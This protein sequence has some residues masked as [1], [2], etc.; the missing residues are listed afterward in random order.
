MSKLAYSLYLSNTFTLAKTMVIKHSLMAEIINGAVVRAGYAVNQDDPTT[1]KYY[2]NMA[3]KYHQYDLDRLFKLSGNVTPYMQIT[4]AG[5]FGPVPADFTSILITGDDTQF[6]PIEPDLATANEYRFNSKFYNNLVEKY[7]DFQILIAGILNPID[8]QISVNAN[9]GEIL[10]A[11]GFYKSVNPITLEPNFTVREGISFESLVLIEPHENNLLLKLQEWVYA[12]LNAWSNTSYQ[13]VDELFFQ[14]LWGVMFLNIPL[15][16]LNIRLENTKSQTTHT[17]HITEY[18]ESNGLLGK[19]VKNLPIQTVLYIY[20]NLMDLHSKSGHKLTAKKVVDNVL[21]PTQIPLSKYNLT[22]DQTLIPLELLPSTNLKRDVVNFKQS[23]SGGDVRSIQNILNRQIPLAR[24][25]YL[26]LDE[27]AED[28]TIRCNN[29]RYSRMSTK[30]FD[31]EMLDTRD[32]IPFP[33]ADVLYNYWI[34]TSSTGEYTG[35]IYVTNPATGERVQLNPRSSFILALYCFN[36]GYNDITLVDI[37]NINAMMIP[38]RLAGDP[39]LPLGLLPKP[40][41]IDVLN[42]VDNAKIKITDILSVMPIHVPDYTHTASNTFYNECERIHADLMRCYYTYT[43]ADDKDVR[44]MLEFATSE[45][46]WLEVPCAINNTDLNY[47]DWLNR[48]GINLDNLTQKDYLDFALQIV[49]TVTGLA[50]NKTVNLRDVQLSALAVLQRFNSYT[51]HYISKLSIGNSNIDDGKDLRYSDFVEIIN[52]NVFADII[53]T[54]TLE[55][56]IDTI[57]N[58]TIE[59]YGDNQFDELST[60]LVTTDDI[61]NPVQLSLTDV[62][63]HELIDIQTLLTTVFDIEELP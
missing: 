21:T 5:E 7:P 48:N 8:L 45:S 35:T 18:L 30:V 59:N 14:A 63:E 9:D 23:G 3:G 54:E 50:D 53:F 56:S 62:V 24:N 2:M 42:K 58:F 15:T 16:I 17:Y 28:I 49:E 60:H 13:R 31:S 33:I 12:Y 55:F 52:D 38:R 34:Y 51:V 32:L 6:P 20:K 46:Y 44:A 43:K 57:A 25:N 41:P 47:A 26:N 39:K 11:G 1:W 4:V 37:P 27:K 22:H 29:A 61:I 36:K 19:H 40:N 10:Y